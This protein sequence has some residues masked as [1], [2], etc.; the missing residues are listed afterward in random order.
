MKA[1][2]AMRM[3]PHRAAVKKKLATLR[4]HASSSGGRVGWEELLPMTREARD[5]LSLEHHLQLEAL[6][7][8]V[9]SLMALQL[10]MRVALAGSMLH[11]LG[12]GDALLR[13]VEEYEALAADAMHEGSGGL[14]AFDEET[15]RVFAQLVSCHDR[16]LETAPLKAVRHVAD[17][18]AK[19]AKA[20]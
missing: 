13:P 8:G 11:Q 14:F 5:R 19:Y 6:R 17:K 12:Y 16:Q 15:F 10:L 2:P 1:E 20:S 4:F 18:L 9:G 3:A 7:A